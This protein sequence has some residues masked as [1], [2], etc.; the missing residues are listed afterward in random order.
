MTT[1]SSITDPLTVIAKEHFKI[2]YLFPYQRLV[3]SNILEAAGAEGFIHKPEINP[4]TGK[5]EIFDTRPNQIVILPT[6]AGKSLCFMLPAVL[7][8][9]LTI[10]VFPLL[11]LIAD[12]ARRLIEAGIAP[13]ILRGG[14]STAEREKLWDDVEK[15]LVKFILTNPETILKTNMLSKLREFTVSHIVIDEV[16]TVSEWGDTFRP[17][18]LELSKLT[19]GFEE[20]ETQPVVTA[21][22]ATASDNILNRVCEIVFPGKYPELIAANPDRPNIS[23]KVI[24]TI[25]KNRQLIELL[26]STEDD[27]CKFPVLIFSRSRSGAELIAHMLRQELGRDNIFF[28]HAGLEREEKSKIQEWFYTSSEGILVATI[29]FGMGIDKKDVRT[30][31]HMEPSLTV[32]A[33]LQESGRAGRDTK[34]SKA[35]M[36]VSKEDRPE[37]K[38]QNNSEN[39]TIL[40]LRYREF[41]TAFLN[42]KQCRR[43]SLLKLMGAEY[44]SCFG[45]DVCDKAIQNKIIGKNEIIKLV[46]RYNRKLTLREAALTLAES[47]Y[48][49]VFEKKLFRLRG[50]G[51]LTG[52]S[53]DDVKDAIHHLE[54]ESL[55]KIPVR[56]V[57]KHRLRM[58]SK[59]GS[60]FLTKLRLLRWFLNGKFHN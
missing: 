34:K 8:S 7:L 56:G 6:G 17:V 48:T 45:C 43:K 60:L 40:E 57:Y 30:V 21:F 11:S 12:Q 42:N 35:V 15:G 22:T 39:L 49:D 54:E 4:V 44:N 2:D 24:H 32:E 51:T 55:I 9:G 20:L 14:Q 23:Y 37:N 26:T 16:H 28:F 29:A 38:Q 46:K 31:I 27:S 19:C 50:Y 59:E 52:W 3:I 41:I 36:L 18:Y 33:Y 10:V 1:T 5:S 25:S 53:L 47:R 13:G 58:Q